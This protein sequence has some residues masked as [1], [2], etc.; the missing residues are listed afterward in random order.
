MWLRVDVIMISPENKR[1]AKPD[2]IAAAAECV[3]GPI[4]ACSTGS[5]GSPSAGQRWAVVEVRR[6]TV[7]VIS[8]RWSQE[9]LK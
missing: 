5:E 6:K 9:S 1:Q 3:R 4:L 2:L 8:K 7:V